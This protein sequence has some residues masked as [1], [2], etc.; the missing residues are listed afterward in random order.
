MVRDHIVRLRPERVGDLK[1]VEIREKQYMV[2]IN[3][4]YFVSFMCPLFA[5][6]TYYCCQIITKFMVEQYQHKLRYI[7]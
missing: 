6:L 7:I 5:Q 1:Q 3:Q 4:K 2:I